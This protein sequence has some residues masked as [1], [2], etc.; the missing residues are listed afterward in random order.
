MITIET[1]RFGELKVPRSEVITFPEGLVGFAPVKEY[2]IMQ[3][4]SGGPFQWLQAA[5]I[6]SLAFVIC[7]PRVF[8]SDYRISVRKEDLAGIGIE[9]VSDGVVTVIVVIPRGGSFKEMTANLKGP[10]II[11]LSARLAKQIVLVGDEY[12]L[13]HPVFSAEDA[14]GQREGA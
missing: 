10:I 7:D 4:P 9:D 12:G 14:A 8:K 11:N 13:K 3:N 2:V 1:T 5:S 6:P